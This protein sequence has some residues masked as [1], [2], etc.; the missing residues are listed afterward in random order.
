MNPQPRVWGADLLWLVPL[1]LLVVAGSRFTNSPG[2]HAASADYSPWLAAGLG[3]A[4]ALGLFAALRWP[5]RG[6][7]TTFGAVTLYVAL[8]LRDGPVYLSLAAASFL[9]AH[10]V[11]VRQWLR[12]VLVGAAAVCAALLIRAAADF[13]NERSP[14]QLAA[15][16]AVIA[17]GAAI[18]ALL[19]ARGLALSE[20]VRA[21]ATGEQ[22]RMAQDIH[23]GVGHGLAVIAM[24]AGVG[25]HVLDRDPAA[26][27]TALE[28]IRDSARES[29]DALR[30][31]LAQMAG[32][33]APRQPRHGTADID[34]LVARVRAAGL[35]VEV[36]GSPG[37]LAPSVGTVVYGVVQEGL[38]NVLR[39]AAATSAWVR[40]D[41]SGDRLAVTVE[42]DGRGAGPDDAGHTEGMGLPG[43]RRRVEA[44]SGTFSV[45]PASAGG[46][47]VR[48]VLPL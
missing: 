19:R 40:F 25:L 18:G 38:T 28:A 10:R 14:W 3:A 23:D 39:H 20:R 24:Q 26:A 7:A 9:V 32:E 1:A 22:L 8:D 37:E 45:G 17:A 48:A 31:D 6:A 34:E 44:L 29:L 2:E 21:A 41:R 4:A 27:R 5:M 30:A 16:I 42:D 15:V 35:R 12:V 46:F 33:P 43:M 13:D 36:A 47:A 11:A